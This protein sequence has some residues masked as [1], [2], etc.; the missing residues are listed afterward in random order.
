MRGVGYIHRHR[1]EELGLRRYEGGTMQKY[2]S[3]FIAG[4]AGVLV[5]LFFFLPWVTLSCSG[6]FEVEASGYDLATGK[7]A[8]KLENIATDLGNSITGGFNG[9]EGSSGLTFESSEVSAEDQVEETALNADASVWLI[10]IVGLASVGITGA[11][12]YSD[13]SLSVIGG[14]W[15][16]VGLMGLIVQII[17]YTDLQDLKHEIEAQNS[18]EML[19][20]LLRFEY[21]TAWWLSLLAL[22]L[23]IIGGLV[24]LVIEPGLGQAPHRPTLGED[25]IPDWL[26]A[27][28]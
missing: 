24:A 23:I 16:G 8:D 22:G 3:S 19:G 4:P 7:A 28:Q 11:R 1:L 15:V 26:D 21:N 25:D 12:V 18:T 5:V 10:L 6:G 13:L 20:F 27:A 2:L 9:M 14:L 17:K